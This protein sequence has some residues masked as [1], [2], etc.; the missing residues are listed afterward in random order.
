M[1]AKRVLLVHVARSDDDDDDSLRAQNRG[2]YYIF[3]INELKLSTPL[4]FP[5]LDG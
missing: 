4:R 2:S 5:S 3:S 1:S